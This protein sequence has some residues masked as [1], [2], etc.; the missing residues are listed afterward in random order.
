MAVETIS[1]IL[2]A[3]TPYSAQQALDAICEAFGQNVSV[4]VTPGNT[5]QDRIGVYDP[6]DGLPRKAED[7]VRDILDAL[8]LAAMQSA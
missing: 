2:S 7:R 6:D 1:V 4:A 3:D 8:W 5:D